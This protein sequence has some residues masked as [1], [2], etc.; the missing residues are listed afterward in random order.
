MLAGRDVLGQLGRTLA[1]DG[2]PLEHGDRRG[3]VRDADDEDAHAVTPC[4]F[5][6]LVVGEDLQLDRE[7][8]LAHVDAVGTIE[9]GGREV[10]DAA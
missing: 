7:V 3:A 6:L 9:H 1:V 4:A 8:D 2:D 10:Q 5:A